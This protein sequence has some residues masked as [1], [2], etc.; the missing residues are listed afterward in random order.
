MADIPYSSATSGA[1]AR[2][3]ISRLLR[4]LGCQSVGFMD[5]YERH[6]VV[7]VFTHRGRNMQLRASAQGW[8]AMY[9]RAN[10]WNSRR[11]GSA[12]AYRAKALKQGLIAVNSILRDWVKGQVMAVECG[13][14]SFD[15]AFLGVMLTTDGQPVADR[16]GHLLPPPSGDG[17]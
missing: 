7:L 9:L 8:A 3:E 2:D 15:A 11:V 1:A 16:I 6:E 17:Q 4:S 5:D 13:V 10:P 14:M 12:D